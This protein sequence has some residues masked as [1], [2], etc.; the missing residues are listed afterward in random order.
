MMYILPLHRTDFVVPNSF[1]LYQKDYN[2]A[3]VKVCEKFDVA[4][5]D[6]YNLINIDDNLVDGVHP[7]IKGQEIIADK[8]IEFLQS[9]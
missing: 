6:G 2:D 7:T 4:I 8:F 9:N 1:G 5:L 3:I